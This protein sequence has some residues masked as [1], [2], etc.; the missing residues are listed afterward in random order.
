MAISVS[1]ASQVT[2]Q[3]KVIWSWAVSEKNNK[4]G[5]IQTESATVGE[6]FAVN[7]GLESI[8]EHLDV[9][10]RTRYKAV[11]EIINN[12]EKE[13]KNPLVTKIFQRIK[14]RSG[15]VTALL[16]TKTN[17]SDADRR[18]YKMTMVVSNKKPATTNQRKPNSFLSPSKTTRVKVKTTT[19]R[20]KTTREV[21]YTGLEDDDT[22]VPKV[23][24]PA[25]LKPVLCE[26]C[27]GPINPLTYECFCSA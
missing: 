13:T 14:W 18:A 25:A 27:D 11:A 23:I 19:R 10:I 16:V 15:K 12:G 1:I 3:K 6:L 20:P 17:L 22:P 2:S 4:F 24:Q 8:P 5:S 26:S 21:L 9:I 7:S